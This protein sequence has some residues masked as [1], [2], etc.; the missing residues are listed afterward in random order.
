MRTTII[1]LFATLVILSCEK[2]DERN[3][4][5]SPQKSEQDP[6]NN[7]P[8]TSEGDDEEYIV[9]GYW[10]F[11]EISTE[12]GTRKVGVDCNHGWY[13]S[14]EGNISGLKYSPTEG[15]GKGEI[16]ITYDQVKYTVSHSSI[17]WSESGHIIFHLKE[18]TKKNWQERLVDIYLYRRGSKINL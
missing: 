12:A 13:V 11:G 4:K 3:Q 16:T 2:E 7:T 5:G 6:Q 1:V 18:R 9:Y 8:H 15:F 14:Y 17:E 10:G